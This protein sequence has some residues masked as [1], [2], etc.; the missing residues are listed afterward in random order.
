M[1]GALIEEGNLD[2]ETQTHRREGHATIQATTGVM[3]PQAQE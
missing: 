2:T 3:F 1:T